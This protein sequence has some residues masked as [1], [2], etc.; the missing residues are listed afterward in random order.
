MR[1]EAADVVYHLLVGLRLRGVTLRQVI[2]VLSKRAG[3]SGLT[4]KARRK[5]TGDGGER[6][7]TPV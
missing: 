3:T 5:G 4:E 6:G 1:N 2:E 7:E